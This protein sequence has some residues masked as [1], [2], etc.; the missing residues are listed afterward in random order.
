MR[1]VR[2]IAR[3]IPKRSNGQHESKLV[4]SAIESSLTATTP[5]MRSWCPLRYFVPE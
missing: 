2:I 1:W 3:C 5:A 4:T